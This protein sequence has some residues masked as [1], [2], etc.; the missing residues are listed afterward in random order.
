MFSQPPSP[1]TPQ[2]SLLWLPDEKQSYYHSS[3][4][5][6]GYEPTHLDIESWPDDT[7]PTSIFLDGPS[8]E[9]FGLFAPSLLDKPDTQN[10]NDHEYDAGIDDN[11][12]YQ[13]ATSYHFDTLQSDTPC[14]QTNKRPY[15]RSVRKHIPSQLQSDAISLYDVLSKKENPNAHEI[16]KLEAL[17][18]VINEVNK[19]CERY[20]LLNQT[21]KFTDSEYKE[22]RALSK[23][24][25][26]RYKRHT[27]QGK[28]TQIEENTIPENDII[29]QLIEANNQ[30]RTENEALK[31]ELEEEKTKNRKYT[32]RIREHNSSKTSSIT[33]FSIFTPGKDAPKRHHTV[34]SPETGNS[35]SVSFSSP[36]R[37]NKK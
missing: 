9:P 32:K 33:V 15:I 24:I 27:N 5:F 1:S 37:G 25:N 23:K 36:L 16:I 20:N 34:N 13:P 30:L 31:V 6:P 2:C 29:S 7:L 21:S 4:T 17:S 14:I 11:L 10:D 8:P 28:S 26:A 12:F 22:W 3:D 18:K 19:E 35:K